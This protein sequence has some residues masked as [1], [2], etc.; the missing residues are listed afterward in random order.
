LRYRVSLTNLVQEG[1]AASTARAVFYT[2][3]TAWLEVPLS[4]LQTNRLDFQASAS[5]WLTVALVREAD[6]TSCVQYGLLYREVPRCAL[7]FTSNAVTV[8]ESARSVVLQVRCE[9]EDVLEG[10]VSATVSTRNGTATAGSD[11]AATNVTV[12]WGPADMSDKSVTLTLLNKDTLWEGAEAFFADLAVDP[13][14]AQ[15]LEGL[16]LTTVTLTE[17][18]R[19]TVPQLSF[20][21][22]G[23]ETNVFS[24]STRIAAKEGDQLTFWLKRAGKN[25][26]AVT[27]VLT[28]ADGTLKL[29]QT[30][31]LWASMEEGLKRVE[32]QVPTK[33]G[34]Q[35][36]RTVTLTLT[37]P[38][39]SVAGGASRASLNVTDEAFTQTLAA[40]AGDVTRVPF[41]AASAAWFGTGDEGTVLRCAPPVARNGSSVMTAKVTGPGTILFN[42]DTTNATG[43]GCTFTVK[44]GLRTAQTVTNGANRVWVPAGLQTVTWTFKRGSTDASA[45]AYGWVSDIEWVSDDARETTGAFNGYAWRGEAESAVPEEYGLAS[46]TVDAAGKLTGKLVFAVTNY[47]FDVTRRY[48][49]Q[50]QDG[51]YAATNLLA[52]ASKGTNRVVL[53]LL[54][55]PT[56]GCAELADDNG[57]FGAR[58]YRNGWGDRPLSAARA[59]AVGIA[60]GY[61][62]TALPQVNGAGDDDFGSGFLALTVA[63]ND[64]TVKVAG[65]LADGKSGSSS[66]TLLLD[67]EGNV[68]TAVFTVPSGY[69]GGSFFGLAEFARPEADGPTV[70]RPLDGTALLWESRNPKATSEYGVGFKRETG[71]S[72]GWYDTVGNLY[73]YYGGMT[74]AVGT[75][76]EPT[77]VLISGTNRYESAWWAPDGLSLTPV[78]NRYGVMT[79]LAAPKAGLPVKVGAD[80]DYKDVSNN[81]IGLTITLTRPTGLFRGSYKAWFDYGTTHTSRP[82]TFEGALTPEREDS[83]D[84]VEGRGFFLWADKRSYKNASNRDEAYPFDWSYDFLLLS[85]P[86]EPV[87]P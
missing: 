82:V 77:P 11:Y 4:A 15:E 19:P 58:L 38:N 51:W 6:E 22:I 29:G 62:T 56:N 49:D 52:K 60:A 46:L 20:A 27:S 79:G 28:W 32:V 12:T 73:R 25:S 31:A 67:A 35:Q 86:V 7:G 64:G 72:G 41:S 76:N 71:L 33:A 39:A 23:A 47:A 3:T 53:T 26:G 85:A 44:A 55:N 54:V 48:S 83:D 59:G 30:N 21:G 13:D 14:T 66:S 36:A 43:N 2:N 1:A 74:L 16:A 9:A 81:T 70:V 57:T 80:Y 87:D 50:T 5:G 65:K 24:S 69:M 68:F 42:A 63:S 10:P 40:Y 8:S 34:Y 61:Y 37:S 78:T 75:A 84:G 45:G 18:D 17:K